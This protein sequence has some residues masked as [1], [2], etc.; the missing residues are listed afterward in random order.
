MYSTCTLSPEENEAVV[1]F[2][3]CNYPELEM[4]DIAEQY[5]DIFKAL[6]TKP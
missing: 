6:P 2:I 1:H 3:L 5:N 4:V